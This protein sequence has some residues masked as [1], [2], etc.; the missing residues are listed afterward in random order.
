MGQPATTVPDHHRPRPVLTFGD[1]SLELA[2]LEGMVLDVHRQPLVARIQAGALGGRPAHQHAIELEPEVVVQLP[3][4]V[5]VDHEG[6]TDTRARLLGG[7]SGHGLFRRAG[8][9]P[10]AGG[11]PRA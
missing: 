4:R 6:P 9:G 2:I 11:F 10:A 3:G 8:V 7:V 1:R 5:L